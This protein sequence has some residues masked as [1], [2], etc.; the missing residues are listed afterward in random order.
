[1]S[2]GKSLR[3]VFLATSPVSEAG[4]AVEFKEPLEMNGKLRWQIVRVLSEGGSEG[5]KS[6]SL[7]GSRE[8]NRPVTTRSASRAEESE[9]AQEAKERVEGSGKMVCR[10]QEKKAESTMT[11]QALD[12]GKEPR[13]MEERKEIEAKEGGKESAKTEGGKASPEGG[14]ESPGAEGGKESDTQTAQEVEVE[15]SERETHQLEQTELVY[16]GGVYLPADA[17]LKDLRNK[18]VDSEQLD[19]KDGLYFQ[20]LLSDVP[21][22]RIELDTED[23]VLLCQIEGGLLQRRTLYIENIDP[24]KC[25]N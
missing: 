3:D 22:D 8:S 16:R 2:T 6:S 15:N 13:V 19:C 12:E 10:V 17:T 18:F 9:V 4:A 21:G 23:E 20:F 25:G 14:K 5:R 11:S 1:M 7:L 24:G